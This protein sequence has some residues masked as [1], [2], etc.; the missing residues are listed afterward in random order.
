MECREQRGESRHTSRQHGTYLT[1]QVTDATV[2]FEEGPVTILD[3]SVHGALLQ[4]P[5]AFYEGNIIEVHGQQSAT[6]LFDVRWSRPSEQ[7]AEAH[8]YLI[9]CRRIFGPC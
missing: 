1:S 8:N 3:E 5:R 7:K 2:A 9:G 4:T 6:T